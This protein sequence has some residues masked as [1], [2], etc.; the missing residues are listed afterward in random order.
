MGDLMSSLRHPRVDRPAGA[1]VKGWITVLEGVAKD[2][3]SDTIFI[4]GHAKA[5]TPVTVWRQ[6]LL[7]FRDYFTAVLAYTQ[8][9]IA[10]GASV[11]ALVANA[12]LP[13]EFAEYEGTPENTLRA[14]YDE[15]TSKA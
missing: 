15:L 8:K 11:D 7:A 3:S 1:S 6:D 2:H 12:K 5:G 10:A 9:A 14:A 4:A 13:E